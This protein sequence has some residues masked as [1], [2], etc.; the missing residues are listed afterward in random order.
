MDRS[1]DWRHEVVLADGA[2]VFMRP[3]EPGDRAA[4]ERL[5]QEL[6]PESRY[7]R[8]LTGGAGISPEARVGRTEGGSAEEFGFVALDEGTVVGYAFYARE[9]GAAVA[10]VAF[11][12]A[13]AYQGRGL[14]T[15]FLEHLATHAHEHGIHR[16][17]AIAMAQNKRMIEVF[18]DAGFPK[19]SQR[20]GGIVEVEIDIDPSRHSRQAIRERHRRARERR[21]ERTTFADTAGSH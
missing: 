14:G 8:Y 1:K 21:R 15:L 10:E 9:P 3:S 11:E 18:R 12:V 16:F 19:V 17:T 4:I 7:F 5:D 13:D 20:T 2:L 6:S